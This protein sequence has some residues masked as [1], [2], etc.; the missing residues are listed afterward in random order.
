MAI[1]IA[2][3]NAV[4]PNLNPSKITSNSARTLKKI[5]SAAK[6]ALDCCVIFF[7]S[8][9]RATIAHPNKTTTQIVT[10]IRLVSH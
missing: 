5:F 10:V 3:P 1:M 6:K 4:Q 8:I 7:Y 9:N 2:M